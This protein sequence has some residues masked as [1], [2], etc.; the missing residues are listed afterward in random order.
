MNP[1]GFYKPI[2]VVPQVSLSL[3]FSRTGFFSEMSDWRNIDGTT[4]VDGE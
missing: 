2:R 4:T 1:A 3:E